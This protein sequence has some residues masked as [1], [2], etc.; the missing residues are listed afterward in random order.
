MR[1][2]SKAAIVTG[3]VVPRF[4]AEPPSWLAAFFERPRF[5][6]GTEIGYA[7]TSNVLIAREALPSAEEAF[8]P[9]FAL[10]GGSDT[11]YFMRAVRD[12]HRIVWADRAAVVESMP[13]RRVRV[14]WLVRRE[15]RRGNTLSL[16]LRDLNDT[17][18]AR[19]KR[20]ARVL[21]DLA[22]GAGL[23]LSSPVRGRA[24]AIGMLTG[25]FGVRYD[26]Y[27]VIHGS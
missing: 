6:D 7:R 2:E 19:A 25:L 5:P 18:P 22:V 17:W 14:G 24:Q 23:V 8:S 1:D 4:E 20:V 21:R 12:G 16:C 9:K 13:A 15:Y 27:A 26:E 11:H 3:P 10:T